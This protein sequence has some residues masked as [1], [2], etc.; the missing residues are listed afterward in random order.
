MDGSGPVLRRWSLIARQLPG[1]TDND[2]K[3]YWNTKLKKKLAN[4]GIDPITHKP[5]SQMIT[6]F[7]KI[8]VHPTARAQSGFPQNQ[9]E[10]F[11]SQPEVS[12]NQAMEQLQLQSM[13]QNIIWPYFHGECS[14]SGSIVHIASQFEPSQSQFPTST[15]APSSPPPRN[16]YFVVDPFLSTEIEWKND[17]S[18]QGI[19]SQTPPDNNP[20]SSREEEEK[21]SFRFPPCEILNDSSGTGNQNPGG[22]ASFYQQVSE[23]KPNYTVEGASADSFVESILARDSQIKLEFPQLPDEYLDY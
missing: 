13:N 14:S 19:A 8:S 11:F 10:P 21:P 9:P 18:F 23:I 16:D 12:H 5:F 4:M 7:E 3:N 6:E 22:G 1:R 20:V 2:V 15:T 17:C